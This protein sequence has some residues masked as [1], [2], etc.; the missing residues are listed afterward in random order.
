MIGVIFLGVLGCCLAVSILYV[1]VGL[2]RYGLR[3]LS[4]SDT[5]ADMEP[6]WYPD[7]TREPAVPEYLIDQWT[8]ECAAA[9]CGQCAEQQACDLT[10]T[11]DFTMWDKEFSA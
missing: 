4:T 7:A 5:Q 1:A 10:N 8:A 6:E 2:V 3:G 11:D 9:G